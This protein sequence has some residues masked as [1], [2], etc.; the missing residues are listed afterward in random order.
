VSKQRERKATGQATRLVRKENSDEKSNNN[1]TEK[2]NNEN[3]DEYGESR[4][5]STVVVRLVQTYV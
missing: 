3:G 1:S 4:N 2:N 5:E